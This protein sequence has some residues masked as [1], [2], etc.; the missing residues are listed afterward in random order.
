MKKRSTL[1]FLAMLLL[2]AQL[3]SLTAGITVFATGENETERDDSPVSLPAPYA[4]RNCSALETI[5]MGGYNY[6]SGLDFEMGYTG[7]SNGDSAEASINL[8]GKFSEITF[9]AGYISGH[10]RGATLTVYGDDKVLLD[11]AAL[12]HT[13]IPRSFSLG[14]E[15][16]RQLKFRYF[17][18]A[19]DRT[20]Y[21]VAKLQG[22]LVD[23]LDTTVYTSDEFYNVPCYKLT[24]DLITGEFDMGGKTFENGYGFRM[25]YVLGGSKYVSFN[26]KKQYE[27]MTFDVA[28]YLGDKGDFYAHTITMTIEVDGEVLPEYD[29]V[30]LIWDDLVL[31]VK[32]NLKDVSQVTIKFSNGAYDTAAC[33]MGNIQ[34]KSD[35]KAHGILLDASPVK[36][37]DDYTVTLTD[38]APAY[39]LNPRVYPSDAPREYEMTIAEG[40]EFITV[41]DDVVTAV[42]G[43][44]AKLVYTLPNNEDVE[45]VCDVTSKLTAHVWDEGEVTKAPTLKEKGEK[46]YKCTLCDKTK[47]ETLPKLTECE[48]H[49]WNEGEVTKEPAQDVQGEMTYTCTVCG[50]TKA[51]PIAAANMCGE[52]LYWSVKDGV[53]SIYTPKGDSMM[54]NYE[55]GKAPW[56]E[57]RD[58]IHTIKMSKGIVIG[59]NAFYDLYNVTHAEL[60]IGLT[61][62]QNAFGTCTSLE[63]FSFPAG[64]E[65][66]YSLINDGTAILRKADY[67]DMDSLVLYACAPATK[68][69]V[70]VPDG[71]DTIHFGAFEGC[72][73]TDIYLPASLK[74]VLPGAFK[75]CPEL[76][77]VHYCG[78]AEDWAQIPT[79]GDEPN[80]DNASLLAADLHFR[81]FV[82]EKAAS[83]TEDGCDAHYYCA[84]CELYYDAEDPTLILKDSP[85]KPAEGH[86]WDDGEVTKEPTYEAEG[87]K[88]FTCENCGETKTEPVN[89]LSCTD[90]KWDE[91]KVTKEPTY[92]AEGEKTFTCTVCG[93]T[94]TEA[95]EKLIPENPFEDI[96]DDDWFSDSVLWA[97]NNGITGGI[98]A[99]LFGPHESCTRG[100]V[101]TFL[102]AAA[103][104]PAPESDYN[105]FT[106][107]AE[108]D[109]FYKAVLW[110]VENGITK[111]VAEDR[112]G[113]TQACTRGQIVT[114]LWASHNRP[115]PTLTENPFKDFDSSAYY[116]QPIL[117]AVENSI[118]SGVGE[119]M[120]GP[121]NI[122][123]RCQIVTFLYKASMIEQQPETPDE[124]VVTPMPVPNPDGKLVTDAL[125]KLIE[126]K[127][128]THCYHI[129]R[130]NLPED[131]AAGWNEAMYD[132]LYQTIENRVLK[133]MEKYDRPSLDKM[134]YAWGRHGNLVSI[135]VREDEYEY[136]WSTHSFY[137]VSTETGKQVGDSEI[138]AAY[139]MT[140]EDFYEAVKIVL[141]AVMA[142]EAEHYK[143]ILSAEK[144][145]EL[146]DDTLADENIKAAKPFISP[147]GKLSFMGG[148]Y[149]PAGAGRYYHLWTL[150]GDNIT[151]KCEGHNQ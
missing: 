52:N 93:E 143:N 69:V 132:T 54:Y 90:H 84:D 113:P 96:T 61:Y 62:F 81:I 122:C 67:E 146:I 6:A 127:Y 85:I 94:K 43:G 130:I 13:D 48:E 131:R 37:T 138:L 7:Y 19:Y 15:G 80:G 89:K 148:V 39:D 12:K 22:Q 24:G 16:V 50:K 116:Y 103:G 114:F 11:G 36:N 136:T 70:A 25:G 105:P 27:E 18:S 78:T 21:G 17:S 118:T 65:N 140:E 147:D 75:N 134:V 151:V 92:E 115:T 20:H 31:P 101:V 73:V 98:A 42:H 111:G 66:G 86:K 117:W 29:G 32:L 87:E 58:S 45:V 112:F 3:F 124:P 23:A 88:T 123:T 34:L 135:V 109:Y 9:D 74:L 38:K 107:V 95:I 150:E 28:K 121:E 141:A 5:S 1:K 41:Q 125:T 64:N 68:G 49:T 91:G 144:I 79:D 145:Q 40:S 30:K 60:P 104:K 71:V 14:V 63:T 128:Y 2:L 4:R 53:L 106:D 126:G 46:V 57:Q 10:E 44:T 56:Y 149:T 51:E 139:D 55:K 26:F 120:F 102:W 100:Q 77:I 8:D 137:T 59:E 133:E 129:P 72:G 35:G 119:G 83:C 108:S 76:E 99:N 47:K 33:R 82:P 97:Y 110:A 142:E